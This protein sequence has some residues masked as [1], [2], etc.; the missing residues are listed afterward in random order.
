VRRRV[1]D[2]VWY[3]PLTWGKWHWEYKH[4]GFFEDSGYDYRKFMRNAAAAGDSQ[5]VVAADPGSDALSDPAQA[6]D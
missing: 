1:S 5:E 3:R 4:R 2:A 6:A